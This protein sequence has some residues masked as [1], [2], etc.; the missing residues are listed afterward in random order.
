[1]TDSQEREHP[2]SA[3]AEIAVL[4]GMLIDQDALIKVIEMVD[5]SMFYRE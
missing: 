5:E 3:E 2:Y 4:V 1:M